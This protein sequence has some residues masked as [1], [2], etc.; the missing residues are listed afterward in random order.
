MK[1]LL[2]SRG[3]ALIALTGLLVL[4]SN[5]SALACAA[6]Y[7]DTSGSKMGNAATVG[8]FAMVVIMFFMLGAVAAFGWHLAYRAKHPLPDYQE[9][10]GEDQVQ[11]NPGTSS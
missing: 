5:T 3:V 2:P 7:G 1:S 10:L 4:V 11:P 9:L 8:I 6:C